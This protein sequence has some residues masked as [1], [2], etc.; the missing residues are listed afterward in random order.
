MHPGDDAVM[1][2]LVCSVACGTY[3]QHPLHRKEFELFPF[4]N[5]PKPYTLNPKPFKP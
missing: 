4:A 3:M 2:D 5:N 1:M